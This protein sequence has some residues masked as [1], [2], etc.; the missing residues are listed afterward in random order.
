MPD[1]PIIEPYDEEEGL[2]HSCYLLEFSV[3]P[4]GARQGDVHVAPTLDLLRESFERRAHGADGYLVMLYGAVLHAWVVQEGEIVQGVDL[5][6][7]LRTGDERCDAALARV[8]ALSA[9]DL[10]DY[11]DED[12]DDED[13]EE[14]TEE[15]EETEGDETGGI[16]ARILEPYDFS[17]ERSLPLLAH[18]FDLHERSLDGDAAARAELDRILADADAGKA[19]ESFGGVTVDRLALDWEAVAAAL[20]PLREPVLA[21]KWLGVRWADGAERHPETYLEPWG[22]GPLD[23]LHLGLNDLENGEDEYL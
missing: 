21:T 4:G 22:D 11:D 18:A 8:L 15:T 10:D 19:P 17:P 7:F 23:P 16:V 1:A 6:P 2:P 5:H 12:E 20:P 9:D 14:E 3:S 13:D